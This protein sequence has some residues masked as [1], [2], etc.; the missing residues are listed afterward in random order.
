VRNLE[1]SRNLRRRR[2]AEVAHQ[3]TPTVPLARVTFWRNEATRESPFRKC[4]G[5]VGSEAFAQLPSRKKGKRCAC[6]K[7]RSATGGGGG[8]KKEEKERGPRGPSVRTRGERSAAARTCARPH[9]KD[10]RRFFP[11]PPPPPVPSAPP[12]LR[13]PRGTRA[14]AVERA[15]V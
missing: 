10:F 14:T 11:R 3:L 4:M 9:I 13:N 7:E 12:P 8:G 6:A 1:A 5:N 15:L 2:N